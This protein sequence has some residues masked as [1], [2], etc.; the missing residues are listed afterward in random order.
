MMHAGSQLR[1]LRQENL[2]LEVNLG[3]VAKLSQNT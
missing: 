1:R 3:Y 2:E